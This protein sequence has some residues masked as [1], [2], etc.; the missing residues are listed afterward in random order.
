MFKDGKHVETTDSSTDLDDFLINEI[1]RQSVEGLG[2]NDLI[3]NYKASFATLLGGEGNDTIRGGI[4][5]TISGGKGDDLLR[6]MDTYKYDVGDGNDTIVNYVQYDLYYKKYI[7]LWINGDYTVAREKKDVRINVGTGSILLKDFSSNSI[8]INDEILTIDDDGNVTSSKDEDFITNRDTNVTIDTGVG[9]DKIVNYYSDYVTINGGDGSDTIDNRLS[10]YVKISGGA[11]NDSIYNDNGSKNVTIS[12][13]S[14]ND[15]INNHGSSV[16]IN[17]GEDNDIIY[18]TSFGSSVLINGDNGND[19][20]SGLNENDT[21]QIGNGTTDTYSKSLVGRDIVLTVANGKITLS[22]VDDVR[23]VNILGA[24]QKTEGA[25][26]DSIEDTIDSADSADKNTFVYNGYENVT[27]DYDKKAK[28]DTKGF[29][30]NDFAIADKDLILNFS[31][32]KSLTIKNGAN[33]PVNINSEVNFYTTDGTFDKKKKSID[34]LEDTTTFNAT[35]SKLYSK[36]KLINGYSVENAVS[37]TGNKKKNEI[38]AG[39]YDSTLNGGKGD[40]TLFGGMGADL[41]VYEN[42]SGK[43]VIEDYYGEDLINLDSSVTIK[44]V[45]MKKDRAVLKFKGGSLTVKDTTE[46]TFADNTKFDNGVFV[47]GDTAKVYASFDESI[48]LY[49]YYVKNA[50]ASQGKKT[51]EINGNNLDNSLVGGRGKDYLWGDEGNDTLIGGRGKDSLWGDEGD[52]TLIGGKGNDMLWGDEGADTF[53]FQS[54]SGKDRIEDYNFEEG[55]ILTILDK[56]GEAGDFKKATFK[57][58]TLT[59]SINGGGKVLFGDVYENTSIN[60]NGKVRT[61]SEL[62]K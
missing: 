24:L 22:A 18:N 2:G 55:D 36:V 10:Y 37:I 39:D 26:D 41:F 21:L 62:I 61:V 29:S 1:S 60:I 54:G 14:G 15:T 6:G 7:P 32:D 8:Y 5:S 25:D 46:F 44:D 47:A 20:I 49:N 48:D 57:N 28:I 19:T 23:R 43:D 30:Y 38:Y 56:K 45:K 11:G 40:D 3:N 31:G 16:T 4:S 35:S 58:E 42:K 12:G 34:L 17:G 27:V 53:I 33:K 52:D 51:V 9:N 59:L 50:D 13:D